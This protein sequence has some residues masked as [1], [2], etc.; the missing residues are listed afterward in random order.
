MQNCVEEL[1]ITVS[2]TFVASAVHAVSQNNVVGSLF[3]TVA[4]GMRRPFLIHELGSVR[5]H[6]TVCF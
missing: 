4:S 3:C 5:Y 6:G 2:N 1:Q